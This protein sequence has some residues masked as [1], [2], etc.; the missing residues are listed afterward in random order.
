MIQVNKI[1]PSFFTKKKKVIKNPKQPDSWSQIS[2]IRSDLREHIL[3]SEQDLMCIY[4]EKKISSDKNKSN[5]DHFKTRKLYPEL[6]FEYSNLL[7]SCNSS[8]HCSYI[9]DSLPLT[10]EDY[11]NIINPIDKDV[12]ES[13]Y[14]A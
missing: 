9:K 7:V 6:S 1:E 13:F 8:N 3:S 14:F 4:C 12:N 2:D 5:I 11:K 10:K